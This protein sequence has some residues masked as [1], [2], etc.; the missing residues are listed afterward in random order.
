MQAAASDFY[1]HPPLLCR[2]SS[3]QSYG[4]DPSSPA[5]D[6]GYDLAQLQR[7]NS[8]LRQE[9]EDTTRYKYAGQSQEPQV[10]NSPSK[11]RGLTQTPSLAYGNPFC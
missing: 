7:E 11:T 3:A 4:S 1:S 5:V 10:R 2:P 9:L 8:M 6:G